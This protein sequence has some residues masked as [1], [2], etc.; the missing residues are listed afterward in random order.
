MEKGKLKATLRT[1]MRRGTFVLSHNL[2]D[3]YG[4]PE[5]SRMFKVKRKRDA[6][7]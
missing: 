4:I 1:F 2:C 3:V 7:K 5:G 6:T